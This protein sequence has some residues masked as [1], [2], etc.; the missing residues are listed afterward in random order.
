MRLTK[1]VC[2]LG[3]A[4]VGRVG[5]LVEAGM[6]V[7]RLNF[8]HGTDEERRRA[9]ADV[10]RAA[11]ERDRVVGILAD[12]PGPKVRLGTL[13]NG[14]AELATGA[15]F[16]LR[17]DNG[18]GDASGAPT[19]H[20]GLADD[21]RRGDPVLVGD[22]A[23]E[24]RVLEAVGGDV[25]TEVLRG[26][27]VRSRAGVNIPAARLSVPALTTEDEAAIA[28][29]VELDV[30]LVAQSFVR[31]ARDVRELRA[32]LGAAEVAVVA[33]IE[34]AAAANDVDGIIAEADAI[35]VARG[36]LG[37]EVPFETVPALQRVL[38]DRAVQA[39]T[40]VVIATQMLES[41]VSSPRP[42]RAEASDVANAVFEGVDAIL[43]SAET[44]IGAFPVDAAGAA[45]RT[46]E[47][48]ERSMAAPSAGALPPSPA[49]PVELEAISVAAVALARQ[50]GASAIACVT[51]TG[52]TAERMAAAR[53]AVPVV[54]CCAHGDVAGRLTIRRGIIP[55]LGDVP[56]DPATAGV[57]IEDALRRARVASTGDL[58]VT[59]NA[60][61][62]RAQVTGVVELRRLG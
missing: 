2:T 16:V 40:P 29:A 11:R 30:D 41:M 9:V 12:L 13:Q 22:G 14:V 24:L 55:I 45:V 50:A 18:V 48:A 3:P 58:V 6:D 19:T 5:E 61:R 53:P 4:T 7:A 20:P 17:R 35:M 27:T 37:V 31:S 62:D 26:G 44:A 36:D 38:V 57:V 46:V 49:A 42:T 47:A 39:R 1:L 59:V 28:C 33:K 15:R 23:V 32:R 21:L 43:L 56:D 34:T 10:R 54:A 51:R 52:S 60:D 8:S 25:T